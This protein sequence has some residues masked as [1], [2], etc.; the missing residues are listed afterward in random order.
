M[1]VDREESAHLAI[2]ASEQNQLFATQ[3]DS[4]RLALLDLL[5]NSCRQ[6]ICEQVSASE[7]RPS[8]DCK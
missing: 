5:A 6:S 3:L 4:V 1:V 8:P 7:V 2:L